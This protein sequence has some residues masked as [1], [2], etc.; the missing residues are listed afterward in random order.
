MRAIQYAFDEAIQS[1]WRGRRS[2]LLSTATIALALLVL[3]AFLLLTANLERLGAEWGSSAE[4][5][6]Y[7]K[8]DITPAEQRAVAEA[9]A[10]HGLIA[11][12]E[13]VSKADALVRFRQTFGDLG[14][15]MD[16][17]GENPLP[18][19]FEVRLQPGAEARWH[20]APDRVLV[21]PRG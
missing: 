16:S 15:A 17:L 6:V 14:S 1:L 3:G 4:L 11:A 21:F 7:L 5:S 20:V 2:G 12:N 18:A 10:P 9:V 19:S 13:Y 8:D